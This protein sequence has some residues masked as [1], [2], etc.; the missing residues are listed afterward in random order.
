MGLH[1][2]SIVELAMVVILMDA[3]QDEK[4]KAR[5]TPLTM[6]SSIFF[7]LIFLSEPLSFIITGNKSI[8]TVKSILYEEMIIEGEC[9]NLIKTE[10]RDVNITPIKT[11]YL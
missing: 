2:T 10:E 3:I 6:Q 4:W 1:D 5:N 9:D 11:M 7:L 8:N